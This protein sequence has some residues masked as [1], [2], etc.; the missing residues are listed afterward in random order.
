MAALD[1]FWFALSFLACFL[2]SFAY[3]V[4]FV[5]P[6]A[7]SAVWG[8]S[9]AA[10]ACCCVSAAL[11]LRT[12]NS[13]HAPFASMYEFGLL[14]VGGL[15]LF[16]FW[17]ERHWNNPQ[18]GLCTLPLAFLL[19]GVFLLFY[20]E[21]HPLMPAL[22]SGWLISHVLTAVVAYSALALSFSLALLHWAKSHGAPDSTLW[23]RLPSLELLEEM[24][25]QMVLFALP[26]LTLLLLTGSIWGEYAWGSYW[27][28]DPKETW[29]LITWIVYAIYLH[30]RLVL[31]WRGRRSIRWT[32][33]GFLVVLFTFVG[34]NVLLPGLHSY[35]L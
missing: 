17:S 30:G 9:F 18:L 20:Q 14:F 25:G 32:L 5:W 31:G 26:F 24:S 15:L 16:H 2:A 33:A 6:L 28:W 10:A 19:N 8:R 35:A 11:V 1:Q 23:Q 21:P 34:V 4:A 29:S 12:V 3:I 13:G 27:R 22:K 7:V